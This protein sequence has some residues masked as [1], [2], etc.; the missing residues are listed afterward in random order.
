MIYDLFLAHNLLLC[1]C[2]MQ[3]GINIIRLFHLEVISRSWYQKRV[4]RQ[5]FS[6]GTSTMK[7]N[8]TW[9]L[10]LIILYT[11]IPVCYLCSLLL[12]RHV[13][14]PPTWRTSVS[15]VCVCNNDS[16]TL[17]STLRGAGLMLK[18]TKIQPLPPC[19]GMFVAFEA[20]GTCMCGCTCEKNLSNK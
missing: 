18:H 1:Y 9:K 5:R 2:E 6:S 17:N 19:W 14:R 15:V 12:L 10:E 3:D 16:L 13:N 20:G 4:Q 11:Y 8:I 7:F